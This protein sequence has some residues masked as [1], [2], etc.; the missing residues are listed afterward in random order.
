MYANTN[1]YIIYNYLIF[2]GLIQLKIQSQLKKKSLINESFGV[3]HYTYGL[4]LYKRIYHHTLIYKIIS[5]EL[6]Q[7]I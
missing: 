5:K 7:S 6:F 3:E 1:K 2:T 4:K